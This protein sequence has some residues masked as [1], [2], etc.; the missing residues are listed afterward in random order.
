MRVKLRNLPKMD[1]VLRRWQLAVAAKSETI[2]EPS[3]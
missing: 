2:R 3:I 1:V